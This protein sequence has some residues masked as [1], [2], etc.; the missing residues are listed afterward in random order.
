V[1]AQRVL[2]VTR[3]GRRVG[4]QAGAPRSGGDRRGWRAGLDL[5]LE[6]PQGRGGLDEMTGA[7]V[8]FDQVR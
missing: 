3:E 4:E 5:R 6:S 2:E 8:R 7:R 1:R